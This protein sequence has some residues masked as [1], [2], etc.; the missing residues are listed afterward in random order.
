MGSTFTWYRRPG[1]SEYSWSDPSSNNN[2]MSTT[3]FH[4]ILLTQLALLVN[5]GQLI[6]NT[7]WETS[8]LTILPILL[9]PSIPL[10]PLLPLRRLPPPFPLPRNIHM[11]QCTCQLA[12]V[13]CG[14]DGYNFRLSLQLGIQTPPVPSISNFTFVPVLGT[15]YDTPLSLLIC[16]S[17]IC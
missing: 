16:G 12:F 8:I 6:D 14:R 17:G 5:N 3:S 2:P 10:H 13:N 11:G 1:E 15:W 7:H 9:I 4:E